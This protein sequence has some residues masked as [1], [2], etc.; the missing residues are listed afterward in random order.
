M[1][2]LAYCQLTA[3]L[4][5]PRVNKP[6]RDQGVARNLR[7]FIKIISKAVKPDQRFFNILHDDLHPYYTLEQIG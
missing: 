6:E 5:K 4:L 7:L 1:R 2:C 3:Q